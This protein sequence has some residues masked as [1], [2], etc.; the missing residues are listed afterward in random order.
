MSYFKKSDVKNHLSTRTPQPLPSVP[1]RTVAT[2]APENNP[3]GVRSTAPDL[4]GV[5]P[6]H[7]IAKE[8]S[9][10]AQVGGEVGVPSGASRPKR[11][12]L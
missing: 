7:P 5:T 2:P 3:P 11:S 4:A 12:R 8:F 1:K 9:S 10:Q 6:F